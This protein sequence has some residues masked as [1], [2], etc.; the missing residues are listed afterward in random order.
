[1]ST[2]PCY[3]R[4]SF[5]VFKKTSITLMPVARKKIIAHDSFVSCFSHK[6]ILPMPTLESR[7]NNAQTQRKLLFF[8]KKS[9]KQKPHIAIQYRTAH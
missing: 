2:A 9:T 1:M 3:S 4:V 6:S 7:I 8:L 5:S